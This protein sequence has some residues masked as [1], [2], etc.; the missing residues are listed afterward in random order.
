M[1]IIRGGTEIQLN[2]VRTVHRNT[3]IACGGGAIEVV[4]ATIVPSGKKHRNISIAYRNITEV[5]VY[6]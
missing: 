5:S 1:P 2:A 3:Y 4:I 6:V